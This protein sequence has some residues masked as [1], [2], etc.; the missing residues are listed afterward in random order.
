[1]KVECL[2][3]RSVIGEDI[4]GQN[5]P[6]SRVIN[7]ALKSESPALR[8]LGQLRALLIA[9]PGITLLQL[10]GETAFCS[11]KLRVCRWWV[12]FQRDICLTPS[13]TPSVYSAYDAL[14]FSSGEIDF[15]IMQNEVKKAIYSEAFLQEGWRV[16]SDGGYW[17]ILGTLGHGR[18]MGYWS[19]N[20]LSRWIRRQG[21]IIIRQEYF[22]YPSLSRFFL[23]KWMMSGL[24]RILPSRYSA[25]LLVVQKQALAAV[26]GN[27]CL[28][29]SLARLRPIGGI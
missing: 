27:L 24:G 22:F 1:M 6:R 18:F 15:L 5:V 7:K 10:L 25:Y 19:I 28:M 14:P 9:L 23:I 20:E 26:G 3:N 2:N 29:P 21:G 17:F 16:L 12:S 4:T 11:K 13:P 8:A